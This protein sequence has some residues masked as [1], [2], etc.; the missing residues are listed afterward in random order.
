MGNGVDVFTNEELE[1]IFGVPQLAEIGGGQFKITN[2]WDIQNLK[3][4]FVPQLVGVPIGKHKSTGKVTFNKKV[5]PQLIAGFQA[6]E[7]AGLL[8]KILTYEGSFNPR[9]IA[10]TN[11]V[12]RHT[13]AIAFD[14]NAPFNPFH[15]TPAAKGTKGSLHGVADVLAKFGFGWGGNFKPASV[16]GMHFEVIKIMTATE[17]A[18][19][20]EEFGGK[21][22]VK[23]FVDGTEKKIRV[24]IK[25]GQSFARLGEL[26]A[27]I[28][29]TAAPANAGI[30]TPVRQFFKGNGFNVDFDAKKGPDGAIIMTKAA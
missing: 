8:S 9:K 7:R 15:H 26:L 2:G 20:L 17:I 22:G 29:Q 25:E 1:Q 19:A 11:K 13:Y 16:D 24:Q 3:T 14:V 30:M 6:I 12:S 21:G 27:A 28:G 23:V 18:Q 4:V 10:G 5:A